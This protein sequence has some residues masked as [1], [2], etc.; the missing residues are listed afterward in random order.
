MTTLS[1]RSRTVGALII[2]ALVVELAISGSSP[3]GSHRIKATQSSMPD[4]FSGLPP[5][6]T[7]LVAVPLCDGMDPSISPDG[8]SVAFAGWSDVH[9]YDIQSGTIRRICQAPNPS[10]IAWSPSGSQLAFSSGDFTT[11]WN[12]IWIVR[13]DGSNLRKLDDVGVNDLHPIWSADERSLVWTRVN[14]LWQ[15]DTSGAGGRFLTKAPQDIHQEFARGWT[16]DRGHLIYLSGSVMGEE[17]RLRVVGPDSMD[18]VADSSHVPVVSR[19]EI[20]VAEDGG[21]LYRGAGSAFEFIE[22]GADGRA[23][24]CF[25]QDS[26][27]VWNV[28][29]ARDRSIAVF[30][31]GDQ[32]QPRV[33]LV[34]LR[35]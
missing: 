12:T 28:S 1:S 25:V 4:A 7:R 27:H 35:R 26:V 16:A 2:G 21:L 11:H 20:G 18:D 15:C 22:R 17:F 33:W 5:D 29:L 9:V 34:R 14:R 23:R 19:S 13:A 6:S 8:R 3:S 31:D 32:E 24:H 10:G 30:D